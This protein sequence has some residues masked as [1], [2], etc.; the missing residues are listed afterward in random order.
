MPWKGITFMSAG[1]TLLWISGLPVGWIILPPAVIITCVISVRIMWSFLPSAILEVDGHRVEYHYSRSGD[2]TYTV[3]VGRD[4]K[5]VS[6]FFSLVKSQSEP[7][8]VAITPLMLTEAELF[9][10]K[11]TLSGVTYDLLMRGGYG[12][13]PCSREIPCWSGMVYVS[14]FVIE[15]DDYLLGGQIV[16]VYRGERPRRKLRKFHLRSLRLPK[17]NPFPHPAPNP[18]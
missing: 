5:F 15:E 18:S 6:T 8:P 16:F 4:M 2:S 10:A 9:E 12:R 3:F 11:F 13:C 14:N 1:I 7:I 17:W